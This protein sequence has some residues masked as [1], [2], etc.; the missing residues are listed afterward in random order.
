MAQILCV[1]QL[2]RNSNSNSSRSRELRNWE[3]GIGIGIGTEPRVELNW[4][5]PPIYTRT[6][7]WM[8]Y[9]AARPVSPSPV[10]IYNTDSLYCSLSKPNAGSSQK[11]LQHAGDQK[12]GCRVAI[13]SPPNWKLQTAN[14]KLCA[15]CS[16]LQTSKSGCLGSDWHNWSLACG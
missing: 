12:R 14:C 11:I 4:A 16:K 8:H 3:L 10:C 9:R 7:K 1:L 13:A 6:C 2:L 15:P 5:W